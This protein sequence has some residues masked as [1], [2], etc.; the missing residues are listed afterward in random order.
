MLN[1]GLSWSVVS[2]I[3]AVLTRVVQAIAGDTG[4]AVGTAF[5]VGVGN[6]GGVVGPQI[7]ALSK[8]HTGSHAIAMWVLAGS[9]LAAAVAAA[10][11]QRR[12]HALSQLKHLAVDG[13]HSASD[14]PT[15][16]PAL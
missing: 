2:V 16:A 15:T 10:F 7:L 3:L 11:L 6:A 9:M 5:V 8:Q 13:T 14:A 12:L 1:T 4:A